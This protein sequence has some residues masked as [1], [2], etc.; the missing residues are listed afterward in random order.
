[1][2]QHPINFTRPEVVDQRTRNVPCGGLARYLPLDLGNCDD[3]KL[4]RRIYIG[5]WPAVLADL[6]RGQRSTATSE[7]KDP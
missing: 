1:M 2:I 7:I 4:A 6:Q 3:P 5:V